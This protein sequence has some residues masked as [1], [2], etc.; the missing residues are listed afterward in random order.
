MLTRPNLARS[1]PFWILFAGSLVSVALGVVIAVTRITTIRTV[2]TTNDPN[3]TLEVYSGP[4]WVVFGSALVVAGLVG[5]IA[6]LVLAVLTSFVPA[7]DA[8]VEIVESDVP[9]EE[10]FGMPAEAAP[11]A[12]TI[13]AA[14]P[15]AA[16]AD[17]DRAVA[18]APEPGEAAKADDA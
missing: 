4:S 5:L 10:V 6:C 3:A 11:A 12:S 13:P 8:G 1:V 17:A 7:T 14:P 15:A 2:I 16:V 9:V 18:S